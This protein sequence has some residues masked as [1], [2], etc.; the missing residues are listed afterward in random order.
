V[1]ENER[2]P[3][4]IHKFPRDPSFTVK[5]CGCLFQVR[6]IKEF[7]ELCSNIVSLRS[8][9]CRPLDYHVLL[10]KV[11]IPS[12]KGLSENKRRELDQFAESLDLIVF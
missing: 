7:V 9:G 1:E 11:V 2:L 3:L 12:K 8:I 10:G 4:I 5:L 6:H